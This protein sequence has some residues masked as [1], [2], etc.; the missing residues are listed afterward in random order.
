MRLFVELVPERGK[1]G[2]GSLASLDLVDQCPKERHLRADGDVVDDAVARDSV[3]ERERSGCGHGS[4][5]VTG[6]LLGRAKTKPTLADRCAAISIRKSR[7]SCALAQ[8]L[9]SLT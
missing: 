4:L 8:I 3:D 1:A 2:V 6:D 9:V 7:R 5:V